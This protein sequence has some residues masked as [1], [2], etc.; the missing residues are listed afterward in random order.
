MHRHRNTFGLSSSFV[1]C[2]LLA[3]LLTLQ[4][5]GGGGGDAGNGSTGVPSDGGSGSSSGGSGS[6]SS[7]SGSSAPSSSLSTLTVSAN[8][9][10]VVAAPTDPTPA[11]EV[12]LTLTDPPTTDTFWYSYRFAGTAVAAANVGWS[13]EVTPGTQA[14]YI[15]INLFS[16]GLMGSGT[17]HDTVQVE[18]CTDSQCANQ[19]KGSPLTINVTYTVTGNAASN[20]GYFITP[21]SL[22][23]EAPTNGSVQPQTI[24]VTAYDLPPYGAYVLLASQPGGPVSNLSFQQTSASSEP[25]A[26]GTGT[27]TVTVKPPLSLGPGV[28]NDVMSL[29]IC[30]DQACTKPAVGSPFQISVVYTVT[31]SAGQEFTQ[32][33]VSQNVSALAV[34]PQGTLLYAATSPSSTTSASN[35]PAQL[36]S[37]DPTSG[38]VTTLIASLSGPVSE[39]AI[40]EDG[41]YLY[42]LQG[43]AVVRVNTT[44]WIIDQTVQ[45]TTQAVTPNAIVTPSLIAISPTNSNTWAASFS[46][47]SDTSAFSE[48]EIFD[49]ATPRPNIWSIS[50]YTDI[51]INA[52]WS[53]VSSTMYVV[54]QINNL[55]AVPVTA[56]GLGVSTLLQPGGPGATFTAAGLQ[57][58]NGL[59]YSST[60][61][62]LNPATNSVLGQ[63]PLPSGS[64]YASIT[65]DVANNRVFAAFSQSMPNG[66][67]STLESYNLSAFTPLW[68]ARLPVA[69][70]PLRWGTQGLAW[71]A[72]SSTQGMS[73][74]YIISGIFVAP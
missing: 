63:Y 66:V 10:S 20:A 68:I 56:S 1:V 26:Y 50:N 39:I 14:G 40:S 61:Q 29:S 21:T 65:A 16:P 13:P 17:Y 72:P 12:S 45:L 54:D 8:S 3:A 69:S 67:V 62:V 24:A 41:A 55:S 5:C 42:L 27:L 37:I 9:V 70:V 38:A 18:V 11:P 73:E 74:V 57:L 30:Y 48:V 2:I 4:A 52:V 19:I 44:T 49:A 6:G 71:I 23:F 46:Q 59:L 28:Y 7:G 34:N 60:G 47:Q 36:I 35:T 25:Y 33:I 15:V 22:T 51:G 43:T 53:A 64:P 32:Q 31:A 58:V